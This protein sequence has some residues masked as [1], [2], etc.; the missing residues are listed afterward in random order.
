MPLTSWCQIQIEHTP[1]KRPLYHTGDTIQINVTLKTLPETCANG[2]KQAKIY[3][4]GLQTLRQTEWH[5]LKKGLWQKQLSLLVIDNQ[6]HEA[7][8]TIARKVDK[9]SLFRQEVYPVADQ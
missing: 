6:K 5:E 3:L 1:P 4:S 8:L 7:K 2:M 9:E